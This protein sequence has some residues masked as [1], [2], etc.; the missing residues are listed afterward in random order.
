MNLYN[1]TNYN[2]KYI[3]HIF[4]V[5]KI[6][7]KMISK[8][9]YYPDYENNNLKEKNLYLNFNFSNEQENNLYAGDYLEEI[10]FNFLLDQNQS[11]T[12]PQMGYMDKQSEINDRMRAILI[13]WIIEVHFHFNL[14]Q[15]TLFMAVFIID[16]FLSAHFI[17]KS[18]FQLLGI[19]SLL[20]ACKSQEIYYPHLNK[21]VQ[22]TGDAYT[23]EDI[24]RMENE[25][26][27]ILSFNIVYPTSNDFFN[28]LSKLFNFNRKQYFL[29]YFFLENALIDY[30]MIKYSPNIIAASCI[31][32]IIKLFKIKGDEKIFNSFIINVNNP[33]NIIKEA[34]QELYQLVDKILKSTLN[35]VKNKYNISNFENIYQVM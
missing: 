26:L 25:I 21:F 23:K 31:Y 3:F 33:E 14:K 34:A 30:Q 27:K 35:S 20:I 16:S 8:N 2:K 4:K 19:T 10:Y 32:I 28:I 15:E 7:E 12:K 18:R 17:S 1:N 5:P 6:I 24:I 13:D 22:A 11:D 29:G 9:I